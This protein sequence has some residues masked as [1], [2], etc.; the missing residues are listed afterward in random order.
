MVVDLAGL[1]PPRNLG[2]KSFFMGILDVHTRH[3]WMFMLKHES[4]A[5]VKLKEWIAV[6]KH[7]CGKKLYRFRSDKGGE[8]TSNEFKAWLALHGVTQETTLPDSPESNGMAERLN[9]TL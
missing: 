3:S 7:Q 4:D 9:R 6:A 8:F 2:G 1:V 5:V